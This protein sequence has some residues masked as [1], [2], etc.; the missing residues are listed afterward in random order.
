MNEQDIKRG[1][2]KGYSLR[3]HAPDLAA[4]FQTLLKGRDDD[5]AAGFLAGVR[6]YE[7]EILKSKPR[8]ITKS[9]L[10]KYKTPKSRGRSPEKDMDR[11]DR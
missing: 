9:Y 4:Q 11:D 2:N 3:Q 8:H 5:Y 6:E 10:D 7:Q 1:F